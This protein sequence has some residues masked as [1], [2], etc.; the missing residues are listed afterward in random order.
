MIKSKFLLFAALAVAVLTSCG[1]GGKHQLPTNNEYPVI[2][3]GAANAQ[4]KTTYP[5]TIK[6]IQDVEV[7]PKVSGFITKLYVHEGE[8]VKA[9]Q[10]LF[11]VDNAIYQSAVRQAEAAVASA[12]SGVN[13]AQASVVQAAAALNSALAQAATAQLTYNNSKQLYANK[14]IGDY[15][16]QAAKNGYETAQ[17]AVNQARSGIQAANSGVKQ[18]QAGVKQAQA[19]LAS[20]KENL[21]FCYVK[22]PASGYVGSLPYKEGA[23]VSPS[24]PMPITTISNISTMEV[25]FSMT[26]SDILTL[27]RN[28]RTLGNALNTFPSVS[29]L[30]ADGSVYNHVGKIVKTSG[31]I[32]AATGTVSVI[33]RFPNPESLLKS[34]GSG[35]VVIA[36]NNNNALVIPQDATVQVQDKIFVYK[37]DSNNKVH[38][39][40]IKVNAQNDG[41]NYIVTSGLKLGEKIVSKGLASLQDGMEIKALTPA[42][43]KEALKKAASL[44]ANQSSAEGFLKAMKGEDKK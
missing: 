16:M 24:S 11:V 27:S 21:S 41:I 12:Q 18:A 2:T 40:E 14:V 35:Q 32:D 15:E 39:T 19:G 30:L 13:R 7:R 10:V 22:S 8:A 26:E 36:K 28:N 31:M 6:G 38:Y 29:L 3:I 4:M 1:G 23:L 5:A 20:A 42:Q 9:G 34:G 37:V 43:Y 33:A 44:G 17:A 25:Y